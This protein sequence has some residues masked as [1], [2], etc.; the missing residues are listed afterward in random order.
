M[1][2]RQNVNIAYWR[3][4]MISDMFVYSS[5][6]F[7]ATCYPYLRQDSYYY[8]RVHPHWPAAASICIF[9]F[10]TSWGL[11]DSTTCEYVHSSNLRWVTWSFK[12]QRAPKWIAFV[13]NWWMVG[14]FPRVQR[15][16]SP[17]KNTLRRVWRYQTD[18]NPKDRQHNGQKKKDKRTNNDL[19]NIHIKLKIE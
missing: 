10:R 9:N 15:L 5:I 6:M 7:K 4:L 11:L 8:H 12:Q 2:L 18:Q 14:H 17:L 1:F 19:Q 3:T 16:P 13:S